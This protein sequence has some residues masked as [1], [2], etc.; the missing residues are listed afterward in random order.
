[1]NIKLTKEEWEFLIETIV[2]ISNFYRF[3]D[4]TPCNYTENCNKLLEKLGSEWRDESILKLSKINNDMKFFIDD[5]EVSINQIRGKFFSKVIVDEEIGG[6]WGDDDK[7][8]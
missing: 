3:C 7:I 1:M 6:E 4:T 2:K 8:H 5:K